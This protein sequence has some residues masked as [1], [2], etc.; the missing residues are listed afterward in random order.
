MQSSIISIDDEP[1]HPFPYLKD[2]F[3]N[4]KKIDKSYIFKCSNC[5]K[6][7]KS[8]VGSSSNLKKHWD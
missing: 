7:V 6:E 3:T 1:Q 2:Y 5:G 4:C 8:D